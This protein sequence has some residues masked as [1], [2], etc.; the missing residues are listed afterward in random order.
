VARQRQLFGDATE[1]TASMPEGFRYQ[2]DF[3][4]P[5]TEADLVQHLRML[6]LKPFEFHGHLGNRRA[7]SFGLRYNYDQRE[8][9]SAPQIPT[10]LDDLRAKAAAFA[11]RSAHEMKQV[12]INE[13]RPGAGIGW[14]RDKSEFG[15]VIGVSLLM[16]AKMRLRKQDG[17]K[18]ERRLLVLQPRS[19]YL[20]SGASRREWEQNIPP[21]EKLR[22]SIMF[23]T[24]AGD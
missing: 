15:D 5:Q 24:L 7:V 3:I 17:Q 8:I 2:P 10:F 11:N 1:D 19:I 20:L 14:H 21:V 22:Y 18:W 6:E 12:G 16:S 23:R 13:Y 4:D 9:Q